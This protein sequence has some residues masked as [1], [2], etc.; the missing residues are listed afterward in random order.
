MAKEKVFKV[1]RAKVYTRMQALRALSEGRETPDKFLDISE[2]LKAAASH[3]NYH[4]RNKSWKLMGK[5]IPE[6]WTAEDTQK[7]F[8][9]IHYKLPSIAEEAVPQDTSDVEA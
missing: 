5:P 9:S 2:P 1:K 7:F 8:D 6:S 3:P 4:V